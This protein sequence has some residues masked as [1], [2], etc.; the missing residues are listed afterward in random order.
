MA[1]TFTDAFSP[2]K[3]PTI[4]LPGFAGGV[5]Q[6]DPIHLLAADQCLK[7]ENVIL[8]DEGGFYKRP[9]C[10]A[11]EEFD[12][13]DTAI[14]LSS[15]VFY[16]PG[17]SPQIIVHS[18]SGSL[19]YSDDRGA[20]W[21]LIDDTVSDTEPFCYELYNGKCYMSNGTDQYRSWSG[22]TQTLYP[23]APKGKY[24]RVWMDSMW[25]SGVGVYYD[26]VY[27]SVAGD[28]E[29][30]NASDWVDIDKG[31][32]DVVRALYTDGN[33]LIVFKRI[34]YSIVIDPTTFANKV[35]D[36][37]KGCESHFSCITYDG[38]VL[39]LSFRGICV[40]H[41]DQPAEVIS[42]NIGPT[43]NAKV[44]NY[45]A[46][47]TTQGYVIDDRVGWILP[48][49]ISSVPT[50]QAEFY[51]GFARKPWNFHRIPVTSILTFRDGDE[52]LYYGT[53]RGSNVLFEVF[54]D[55]QGTDN[56][57]AITTVLETG[58]YDLGEPILTKYLRR[59]LVV[60]RGK[61][62]CYFKTDFNNSVKWSSV[63][64]MSTSL[65][66]WDK[67]KKWHKTDKWGPGSYFSQSILDTD[68]YCR[69]FRIGFTDSQV[70]YGAFPLS[71]G[72]KSYDIP[73]GEWAVHSVS[74]EPTLLG[75][76][77]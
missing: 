14:A 40:F 9:G 62:Y 51:P 27:K 46:L 70:E 10:A 6:K 23:T 49:L 35:I 38:N 33:Y 65:K 19:F 4:T 74:I 34:E 13:D 77:R 60:G 26:R 36:S 68:V 18:S 54:K 31:R 59:F 73:S 39:F 12:T 63:V 64:D 1:R 32:G 17:G 53:A 7:Q 69:Q 67:T 50:V 24:I 20:T 25:V 21:D 56:G 66:K 3:I 72:A 16:V 58:W 2:N 37:E 43:F 42:D 41:N 61:V 55:D 15:F 8:T 45:E 76:R 47:N 44:I 71:V 29:T 28:A 30:F 11:V 52:V 5:N 57:T 22:T 75:V 48:E